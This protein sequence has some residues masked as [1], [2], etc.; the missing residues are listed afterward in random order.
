MQAARYQKAHDLAVRL[1]K[2][3]I[4][5]ESNLQN[6]SRKL[7]AEQAIVEQL[8]E[9]KA[10]LAKS[11]QNDSDEAARESRATRAQTGTT[12][13]NPFRSYRHGAD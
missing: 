6:A 5:L 7:A 1:E 9:E 2:D 13:N 11:S 12:L 4:R 10:S 8:T 3:T